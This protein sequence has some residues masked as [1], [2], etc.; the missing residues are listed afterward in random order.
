MNT[1]ENH[2]SKSKPY[3]LITVDTEGD[4]L[5]QKPKNITTENAKFIPRFQELCEKY[6]FK[7]TYLTDYE[8]AEDAYYVEFGTDIIKR[9][10]GEIGMHLHAWNS[11]PIYNLTKD[12]YYYM[13]YLIEYPPEIMD[14]KIMFLTNMLEEKF[15]KKMQSHRAGRWAFNEIYAQL[16]VKYGYAVDC[17]V[18]PHINWQSATGAPNQRGGSNYSDFEERPYFVNLNNIKSSGASSLLE[19]P[20][21]I[22]HNKSS[23]VNQLHKIFSFKAGK[24]VLNKFLPQF[25]WLR[26]TGKN[27]NFLLKIARTALKENRQ[28]IEFIIHSSELMPGAN[29]TFISSGD[30]ERLYAELEKV[31]D[32]MKDKFIGATLTEFYHHFKE[33]HNEK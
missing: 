23:V 14:Q 4:N 19:I 12:D 11:P 27:T 7:P 6:G 26:P 18:T 9:D 3:F 8:M 20:V 32:Y 30:I 33:T 29:P 28:C 25:M 17:S 1:R 31:F 5:W 21:T 16:L 15:N 2:F 22:L 10:A 24:R 13:P